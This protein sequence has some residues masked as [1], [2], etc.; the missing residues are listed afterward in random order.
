MSFLSKLRRPMLLCLILLTSVAML[1]ADDWPTWRGPHRDGTSDEKNWNAR[2]PNDGP[3]IAWRTN[4]G[5]GFSAVVVAGERV[6]A[7]GYKDAEEKDQLGTETLYCFRADDGHEIWK[8]SYLARTDKNL[9]VGGPASTPSVFENRIYTLSRDGQFRCIDIEN[10]SVVWEKTLKELI[11]QEMSGWG[12]S[13]SGVIWDDKIVYQVGGTIALERATGKLAWQTPAHKVGYSTPTIFTHDGRQLAV[14]LSGDGVVLVDL[15]TGKELDF[16]AWKADYD[17]HAATP[18]ITA[19]GRIFAS[20]GYG[21]GCILFEVQNDK[22]V[23]VVGSAITPLTTMGNSMSGCVFYRDCLF[24]FNRDNLSCVDANTLQTIWT[25]SSRELNGKGG[26]MLADGKLI[27]ITGS[28]TLAVVEANPKEFQR[29]AAFKLLGKNCWTMPTLAG[30]RIFCRND[31]GELV[32]V[33]V[34]N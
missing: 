11:G 1:S 13:S 18:I 31:Q 2:W 8:V 22:L 10:G 24:G 15:Q 6:F 21:H 17:I 20:S 14:S 12:T 3:K 23:P 32:A 9:N 30:G 29:L 27:L 16:Y 19:A 4:I 28:G 5:V 7:M 34:R 26:V 25:H 33:D